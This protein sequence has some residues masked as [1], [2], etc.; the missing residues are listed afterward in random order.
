MLHERD[1]F[2]PSLRA[3]A[4]LVTKK[5][6]RLGAQAL[7][8]GVSEENDMYSCS[9][10][11]QVSSGQLESLMELVNYLSSKWFLL[12]LGE[13]YENGECRYSSI[14]RKLPGISKKVLSSTLQN[15]E[16]IGCLVRIVQ[17]GYPPTVHYR[18]SELGDNLYETLIPLSAWSSQHIPVMKSIA[19]EFDCSLHYG[20][21]TPWQR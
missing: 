20:S 6:N 21:R 17:M 4:S 5:R 8:C 13:L 3:P 19:K 15:M 10:R 11:S 12:I 2:S 14:Q 16:R 7:R 18:L 1:R 9:D